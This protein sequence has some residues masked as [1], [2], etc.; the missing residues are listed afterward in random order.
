MVQVRDK[1][2]SDQQLR[3]L[4]CGFRE[5][6]EGLGLLWSINNRPDLVRDMNLDAVHLPATAIADWDP[7]DPSPP[8]LGVS[9]H[10]PSELRA[11]S[12]I[13]ADFVV[14]GPVFDTP[15]KRPYGDPQGLQALELACSE[16]CSL[17][18]PVLA[19]G[20]VDQLT[21]ER[22]LGGGA[23]GVASI[24]ALGTVWQARELCNIVAQHTAERPSSR[25]IGSP[26]VTMTP[27]TDS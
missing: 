6:A 12:K 4:I 8:L 3:D 13:K 20:G 2:A 7:V 18:V 21:A 1:E 25:E 26:P 11:A 5:R 27:G 9:T 15:S 10:S 22:A 23:Y 14:F 24:R 16:A 19:I 17:G